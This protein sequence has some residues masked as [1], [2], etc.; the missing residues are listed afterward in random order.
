[1]ECCCHVWAGATSYYLDMLDKLQKSRTA[2]FSASLESL[3][4]CCNVAN[5]SLH[6]RYNFGRCSSKLAELVRLPH[7]HG[8]LTRYSN[9]LHV[10][11]RYSNTYHHS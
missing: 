5:L 9:T 7:S 4:H 10:N 8:R 6:Y 2:D 11:T 3:T 1:M